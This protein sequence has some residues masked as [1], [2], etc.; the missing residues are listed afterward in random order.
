MGDRFMQKG[1]ILGATALLIGGLATVGH[2]GPDDKKLVVEGVAM[3]T[4]AAPP[5]GSPFERIYSGWRFRK[6][7]TQQLQMDDFE[8]PA[9]PTADQ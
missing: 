6:A 5:A 8:N 9:M 7:E 1:W 3:T 2:A 4:D